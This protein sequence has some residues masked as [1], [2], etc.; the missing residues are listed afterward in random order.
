[1]GADDIF[2]TIDSFE[3]T[4]VDFVRRSSTT[5]RDEEQLAVDGITRPVEDVP[6]LDD[7]KSLMETSAEKI[8]LKKQMVV[9]TLDTSCI[10]PAVL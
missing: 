6:N 5:H 9:V 3:H 7:P 1:M 10:D 8:L 4:K 2:L